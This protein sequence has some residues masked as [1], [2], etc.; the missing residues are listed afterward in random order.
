MTIVAVW[1]LQDRLALGMPIEEAR[2]H[3]LLM[4]V[5]FQIAFL[6]TIR[7]LSRPFWRWQSPENGWMFVGMAAAILLQIGAMSMPFLQRLLGTG[8]VTFE[9][10]WVCLLAALAVLLV[11]EAAKQFLLWQERS[12]LP[13]LDHVT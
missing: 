5:T 12:T 10:F 13:V 2:N 4:V 3:V 1:V 8:P 9:F 6:L 7:N 11:T